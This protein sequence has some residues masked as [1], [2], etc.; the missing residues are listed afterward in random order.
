[1]PNGSRPEST[2]NM[3][4]K[5]PK[6]TLLLNGVNTITMESIIW[7]GIW[8]DYFIK[9]HDC[10]NLSNILPPRVIMILSV[11]QYVMFMAHP[12]ELT[13]NKPEIHFF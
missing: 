11:L 2:I 1:M 6:S 4:D 5:L 3:K 13:A 8:L 10:F 7:I 9:A 12:E